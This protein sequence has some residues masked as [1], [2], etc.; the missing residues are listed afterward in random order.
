MGRKK[1]KRAA[2]RRSSS[3]REHKRHKKVL[4]PP[5]RALSGIAHV[6]YLRDFLPDLL[7]LAAMLTEYG[8]PG[9]AYEP[10]DVIQDVAP[11]EEVQEGEQ[12]KLLLVDGRISAFDFVRED[13][14][15]AVRES[16]RS[17]TPWALPDEFG[18]ALALYPE[19][20]ASWLYDDWRRDNSADPDIGLRYMA[21]LVTEYADRE[22]V[23]ASELR[24]LPIARLAKAG[25]FHIPR[26]LAE[27]WAAY[28][29]GLDDEGRQKTLGFIRATYNLL[30]SETFAPP[31]AQQWATDF[32]RQNWKLSPC[33][34]D[35]GGVV[36]PEDEEEPEEQ[37]LPSVDPRLVIE[38]VHTAWTGALDKLGAELHARQMRAELDLWD[39]TA[40]EVRLGL[41]SRQFRL[42]YELIDDPNQWTATGA[43]H[44]LRSLIETR[45]TVGWL[46][47]KDDRGLY[48]RFREYGLG[49]NKLYKLHLEDYIDQHG[50]SEDLDELR[51]TLEREVNAE[52]LEEFQ[53]IDLGGNFAGVSIRDM[54]TEAD[55]R[56]A[57]TLSYQP[58]SSEA[59]GEW[60][61]I[62][63][64][65]LAVCV[66]PLHRHH[67]V[68]RMAK[69][70]VQP[71]MALL[72]AAFGF[73]RDTVEEVFA[74]YGVEVGD[75]FSACIKEMNEAIPEAE[76]DPT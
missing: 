37:M 65:D 38:R 12:K 72:H 3:L 18:H 52:I 76:A 54:A 23:P 13:L 22:S 55:L 9:A 53:D 42:F 57:Y 74:H 36:I 75:A 32:W 71:S 8:A 17:K 68:A 43:A 59:H 10:L 14:R 51:E 2:R 1:R 40:D 49:K 35:L 7:W 21:G 64:H 31:L 24:M 62:R 6:Y 4:Q 70:R 15:E 5:L 48:E 20:P 44:I 25:K 45:I 50:S 66:N 16:L 73:T 29:D 19:S 60:S 69:A 41:A 33:N 28:P 39:P 67:R 27:E 47:K 58:L 34:F 63:A 30:G 46:L 56:P 61:S 11:A 26:S